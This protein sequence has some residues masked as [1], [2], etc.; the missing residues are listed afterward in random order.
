[1]MRTTIST[2]SHASD[3]LRHKKN[4]FEKL[5]AELQVHIFKLVLD[6]DPPRIVTLQRKSPGNTIPALMHV[7]QFWR[8]EAKKRYKSEPIG[9]R[10]SV[11]ID[12]ER[13][14][15][16]VS[17]DPGFTSDLFWEAKYENL[18]RQCKRLAITEGNTLEEDDIAFRGPYLRELFMDKCKSLE[19][20]GVVFVRDES[21][22]RWRPVD[23][24]FWRRFV[25]R[26][27]VADDWG[28]PRV[29]FKILDL[30]SGEALTNGIEKEWSP[31][32]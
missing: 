3:K 7:C 23:I 17:H 29:W 15:L 32:D 4:L 16:Y 21:M 10:Y 22:S 1:M 8:Y 28:K 5:P 24:W 13:D 6:D 11:V 9:R 12:F 25:A 14:L 26:G 31:F 20:F 27:L 30:E 18:L 19:E 2:P